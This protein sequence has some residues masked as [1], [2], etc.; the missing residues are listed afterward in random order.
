MNNFK[1][2]YTVTYQYDT[3]FSLFTA[4]EFDQSLNWLKNN[5]FD[6]AEICISN[7]RN[8]NIK[9]IKDKLSS[10]GLGC[11]TISTGQ[12]RTLEH[13]SLLDTKENV[14]VAQQRLI[15]HI[16]TASILNSKVTIGL[17]RGLGDLSK[18]EENKKQL[19]KNLEP[20]IAEAENKD[21]KLILECINRYETCLFNDAKS[22]VDF[23][24]T[25]LADS[26]NVG[27]LWDVF[28]A[29]IEDPSFENALDTMQDK[30]LHV[31]IA[32]SNRMF[33]GFGHLDFVNLGRLL[34][35]HNYSEYLSFE[36][37]NKPSKK[38][39]LEHAKDFVSAMKAI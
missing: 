27:I 3:P 4:K 6:S 11:S 24:K 10:Y 39:I 15:E 29:N 23:I 28:H 33:P 34:K 26:K 7:Y 1:Y 2:S 17:I 21:V 32:D 38:Y 8:I 22:T 13:I 30:L 37:F 14:S 19:A 12:A 35:K 16:N 25:E 5:D 31:H 36:C 18:V 9:E 20:I